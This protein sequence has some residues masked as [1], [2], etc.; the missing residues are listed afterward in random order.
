[1]ID[2]ASS[3]IQFRIEKGLPVDV[4]EQYLRPYPEMRSCHACLLDLYQVEYEGRLRRDPT[5]TLEQY[6]ENVWPEF[7][8][9]L[10]K[11]LDLYARY[12]DL[13]ELGRGGMGIVYRAKQISLD[14]TVALKMVLAGA[15]ADRNDRARFC[16]EAKAIGPCRWRS[17]R[18]GRQ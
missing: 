10:R 4:Q 1:L 13:K 9:D 2:L 7:R 6:L 16:T 18:S 15:N 12:K 3:D 5:L 14:R 8:A 11:K 17:P